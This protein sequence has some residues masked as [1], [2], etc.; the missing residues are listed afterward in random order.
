MRTVRTIEANLVLPS[1]D[2]CR[3][4]PIDTYVRY[5][6]GW[7]VKGRREIVGSFIYGPAQDAPGMYVVG[8]RDQRLFAHDGV[9]Q[10]LLHYDVDRHKLIDIACFGR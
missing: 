4:R 9:M 7:T 3:S 6:F 1:N 8:V 5:Y 10:M 2:H